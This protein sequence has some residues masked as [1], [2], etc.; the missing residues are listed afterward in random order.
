V[1]AAP[2]ILIVDDDPE[3]RTLLAELLEVEGATVVQ[4]ADGE[5]ALE[6]LAATEKDILE[7]PAT[8]DWCRATRTAPSRRME[9]SGVRRR[10]DGVAVATA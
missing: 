5:A 2:T 4:A 1:R 7:D 3:A 9:R 8:G 10:L 6:G